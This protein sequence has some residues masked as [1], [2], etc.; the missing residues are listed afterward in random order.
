MIIPDPDVEEEP[1]D[2]YWKEFDNFFRQKAQGSFCD[3]SDELRTKRLKTTHT[4]GIVAK[5]EWRPVENEQGVT[6]SGMYEKGS[7]HA[8]LR[9]SETRN[10]SEASEGLLPS[11]AIKFLI[12]YKKSENLFGMPNLTGLYEDEETGDMEPSWDFFKAPMKNRVDRFTE[13]CELDTVEWK[14][15]EA[16]PFP[17]VTSVVRPAAMATDGEVLDTEDRGGAFRFPYQLEYEGT[18]NFPNDSEEWW[19]ERLK[20]HYNEKF[21]DGEEVTVLKVFGWDAPEALDGQRVHMADIILKT[22][23]YTSLA[24]DSRLFFQHERVWADRR[25]W[26]KE[27]RRLREDPKFEKEETEFPGIDDWPDNDEEAYDEYVISI[28]GD[29]N[30]NAGCPFTW[31]WR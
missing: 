31:L 24:G 26:P 10:L 11:L 14:M 3:N 22:P 25:V 8:I 6:F 2:F 27:W 21:E 5:V 13:E 18:H 28:L 9:L 12:D 29:E 20:E 1:M 16:N 7:H 19:Y 23:L 4:Q 30:G 17:Y 15:R